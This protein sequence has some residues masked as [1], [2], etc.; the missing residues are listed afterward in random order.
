MYNVRM[1]TRINFNVDKNLK[2]AAIK[3]AKRI[4]LS[5]STVLNQAT[6][7][8]VQDH[9]QIGF[10]DRAL[11]HDIAHSRD[12]IEHGRITSHDDLLEELRLDDN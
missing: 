3:K 8:F 11:S 7:A 12:D 2:A 5:L 1:T 6:R 9:P 4:G 10:F